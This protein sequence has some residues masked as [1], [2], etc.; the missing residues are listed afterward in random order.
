MTVIIVLI[1]VNVAKQM[2][3]LFQQYKNEQYMQRMKIKFEDEDNKKKYGQR[4]IVEGDFG[5]IFN[6]LRFISF[7]TRG[8]ENT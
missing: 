3:G 2:L 4:A 1:K 7:Q 6:N 8:K 5:H